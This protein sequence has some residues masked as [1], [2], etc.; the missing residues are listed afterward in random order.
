MSGVPPMMTLDP[1]GY[2]LASG[3]GD[4]Q[5]FFLGPPARVNP[6]P[7]FKRNVSKWNMHEAYVGDNDYL[8][9][10]V[11]DLMLTADQTWYTD[12]AMPWRRSDKTEYVWSN[13]E[14][15]AH[16][17]SITPHQATSNVVTQK[18]SVHRA[19]AIR[20][21]LAFEFENDFV[22]TEL[23]RSSQMASVMQIARAWQETANVEVVRALLHCHRSTQVYRRKH[24]IIR[25]FELDDFL[26]L[27]M[28]R[29]MIAQKEK[30]GLE[31]LN[32]QVDQEQEAWQGRADVW[33]MSR[34]IMDYC[35]TSR[36]EK[37][38]FY[39]GGQEAVDRIN[40]RPGRA[41]RAASNTMGNVD[42]L[43][44]ERMIGD[45]PV[46]LAKAYAIDP[47]GHVNI[48]SRVMEL[49]IYNTQVD[50]NRNYKDYHTDSRMIRVYDNDADDWADI[51]IEDAI[52]NC[53]YFDE[54]TGE[55]ANPQVNG[56]NRAAP[57]SADAGDDFCRYG[58]WGSQRTAAG[59]APIPQDVYFV[60]DFDAKY[61]TL[62]NALAGGETLARAIGLK[63]F[64]VMNESLVDKTI[65]LLG[66]TS[67]YVNRQTEPGV[68]LP[69]ETDN[70]FRARSR[71][72]SR[73]Q[74]DD[75]PE[76]SNLWSVFRRARTVVPD[77]AADY[78]PVASQLLP[79]G[80]DVIEQKHQELF[81]RVLGVVMPETH[82]ERVNAI[83]RDSSRSL[84]ERVAA[85]RE[86]VLEMHRADATVPVGLTSERRINTW[87]KNS[88]E[89][90][91]R[92][93]ASFV[94]Q[95]KEQQQQ[96]QA[97][98]QQQQRQAPV[99]AASDDD[100]H[101]P[102]SL[103][104]F[105]YLAHLFEGGEQQSQ[106]R[107]RG[108]GNL[109]YG[110]QDDG[111]DGRR[112]LRLQNR[113]NNVDA[114][115]GEIARSNAPR[116]VKIL[117]ILYLGARF[118]RDTLLAMAR[119]NI[120]IPANFL[121][122]RAHC[123]YRTLYGIKCA[124]N[125]RS[126]NVF[127]GHM[128]MM[129]ESEASRK[130]G[131]GHFTGYMT[132]VVTQPRNVYV[133]QDLYCQKYLGGMGV[134]FWKRSE[135]ISKGAKRNAKS[136]VCTLLPPTMPQKLDKHIDIRGKWYSHAEVRLVGEDRLA[137][138]C[139]PGASRTAALM[140]WWDPL[141][142]SRALGTHRTSSVDPNYLCSQ[143]VQFHYNTKQNV[144]DDVIIEQSEMGSKVYPG[145][146]K[147]RNGAMKY[148][149]TPAYLSVQVK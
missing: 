146:G 64:N 133:V 121:H 75:G 78:R 83:A 11:E 85:F 34:E 29:F 39:L 57:D 92:E 100:I 144:F 118:N 6:N 2:G 84:E 26:A 116:G 126:G 97:A 5:A 51:S 67:L 72:D 22:T 98:A 1:Y 42:S 80:A 20:R 81:T 41:G 140:Q 9:N 120:A 114:K 45:T 136:I 36:H 62:R 38:D 125:G 130:V 104:E 60:G 59:Q 82:L 28:E 17:L 53:I 35:T 55:L 23:G 94:E 4:P 71:G 43:S 142:G 14:N 27:K 129:I 88:V 3:S 49:G 105:K 77:N 96:Q 30:F 124:E 40:G 61:F 31:K 37:T 44:S 13:W 139:Y 149:E 32:T 15:N 46:Y 7:A 145:C 21:G 79:I 63:D 147:V 108:I 89:T 69:G 12:R 19:V 134:S 115:I 148:L 90:Y 18:R 50:R 119:S 10:T 141:R 8:G 47:I 111:A 48:M 101:C 70:D 54:R 110:E 93:L 107:R 33:I 76:V 137:K 138:S 109:A 117:A 112:E 25:D 99:E 123:Q 103:S 87:I 143:G 68:R 65:E 56:R 135:Y 74:G 102:T 73:K 24:G 122:V 52:M 66:G 127:Y 132:A 128:N 16:F 86:L 91:E 106:Q 58:G 131:V 113:Y 95:H